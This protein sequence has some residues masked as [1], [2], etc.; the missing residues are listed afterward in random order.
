MPGPLLTGL[1]C[2]DKLQ[3]L[4]GQT[5]PHPALLPLQHEPGAPGVCPLKVWPPLALQPSLFCPYQP[6]P[7]DPCLEIYAQE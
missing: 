4:L 5:L 2:P 6:A 7:R 3:N 1:E